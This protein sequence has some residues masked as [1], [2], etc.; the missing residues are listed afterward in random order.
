MNGAGTG[1]PAG[2]CGSD[3]TCYMANAGLQ[4][5]DVSD[6][7]RPRLIGNTG[8][9]RSTR[10]AV[11]GGYVYLAALGDGLQILPTQCEPGAASGD[12]GAMV[13]A[14]GLA[15]FPNPT[16][17]QIEL[18][19]AV[20]AAGPAEIAVVDIAGRTVSRVYGGILSAGRHKMLWDGRDDNG[21][22]AVAGVYL[23]RVADAL[24]T[25][26]IRVVLIR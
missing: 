23:A 19:F 6:P 14:P 1:F 24:G 21:R 12:D 26:T 10:A 22:D 4:V 20:S 8:A 25:R 5:V 7:Q 2:L 15:A 11:S 18:D 16:S 17:R 13:P 9:W 3:S